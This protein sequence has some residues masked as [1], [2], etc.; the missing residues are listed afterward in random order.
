M[1]HKTKNP[2]TIHQVNRPL[3]HHKKN[4]LYNDIL[5]FPQVIIHV[6]VESVIILTT[7]Y[8]IY[9]LLVFLIDHT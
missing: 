5:K 9:I 6:F 7:S 1:N 4:T 2:W 3:P 8:N